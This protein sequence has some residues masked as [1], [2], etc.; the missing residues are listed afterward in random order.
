MKHLYAFLFLISSLSGGQLLATP[1]ADAAYISE[2]NR[3]S[4]GTEQALKT[5]ILNASTRIQQGVVAFNAEIV[6][7]AGFTD[8]L[9]GDFERQF[10]QRLHEAT[11]AAYLKHFTAKELETLAG[12]YRSEQGQSLIHAGRM[13]A[14]PQDEVDFFYDGPGRPLIVH[15]DELTREMHV[16]VNAQIGQIEQLFIPDRLARIMEKRHLVKFDNDF[17]R[18]Q[19]IDGLRGF[20]K[21]T[22]AQ[23]HD[24]RLK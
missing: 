8:A 21:T 11:Q 20:N 23:N 10:L 2:Q 12:F 6:D 17:N 1:V 5:M 16:F 13:V 18:Q 4:N 9:T 7:P 24:D 19:V 3:R 14:L 22:G 15:L